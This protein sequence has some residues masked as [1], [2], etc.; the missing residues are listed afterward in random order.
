MD[1]FFGTGGF[2][3]YIMIRPFFGHMKAKDDGGLDEIGEAGYGV[4][5]VEIFIQY[6]F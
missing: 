6:V 5:F 3:V 2:V 4:S 1:C